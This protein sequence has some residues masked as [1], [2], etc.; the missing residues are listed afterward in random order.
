MEFDYSSSKDP[1]TSSQDCINIRSQSA[2]RLT[3]KHVRKLSRVDTG[4]NTPAVKHIQWLLQKVQC[5]RIP[6]TG[7][8]SVYR[9]TFVNNTTVFIFSRVV[10]L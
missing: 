8:I 2:H 5:L 6:V 9:N 3:E 7:M 10:P 1:Y 4:K